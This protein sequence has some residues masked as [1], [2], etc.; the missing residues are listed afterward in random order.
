[1]KILPIVSFGLASSEVGKF[2]KR[3]SLHKVRSRDILLQL[4]AAGKQPRVIGLSDDWGFDGLQRRNDEIRD[5]I[6]RMKH[7][8]EAR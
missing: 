7:E 3:L 8:W 1:M 4:L 2:S 5:N 6:T